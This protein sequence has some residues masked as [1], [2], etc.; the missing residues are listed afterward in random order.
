MSDSVWFITGAS[1]GFGKCIAEEAL[2]RGHKVIATARKVSTIQQLHLAGAAVLELDVTADDQTLAAKLEEANRIYGKIT[3]VINC[4][5]Y[6]LEGAVEEANSKEVYDQFNTNVFGATNITR[7]SVPY[8]RKSA[9]S[10]S[11]NVVIA[12]F[13][14]L[15]TYWSFPAMAHY[16]ATKAAVSLLT[17]GIGRELAPFGIK[18]CAIEPGF[19]R[20]EFLQMGEAQRRIQTALALPVYTGTAVA[21][22][23]D[24][25]TKANNT[26]A[27]DPEKGAKVIVDVLTRTG[28]AEGKEIPQRL[29]LGS[30]IVG[31]LKDS[32]LT[33]MQ[34]TIEQWGEVSMSTDF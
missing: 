20:T 30:D 28:V 6:I 8:L 15:A 18:A 23:R 24:L 3:H 16:C 14:S 11:P 9:K 29:Q 32:I 22:S 19:F 33:G 12:H 5:G 21:D 13:G 25:L 2:R 31:T 10:G 27:G 7:A 26:Q 1:S 17:D 4:A 34:G